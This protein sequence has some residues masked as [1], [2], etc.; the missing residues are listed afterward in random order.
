[1]ITA[2]EIDLCGLDERWSIIDA[3]QPVTTVRRLTQG[4][5]GRISP[6]VGVLSGTA[7]GA[8]TG[9]IGGAASEGR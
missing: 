1:M 2:H 6:V 3:L 8:A 7:Q 9:A 5:V 4:E